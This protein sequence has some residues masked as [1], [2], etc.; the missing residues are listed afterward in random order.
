MAVVNLPLNWWTGGHHSNNM[1][2]VMSDLCLSLVM[3]NHGIKWHERHLINY[4]RKRV[5]GAPEVMLCAARVQPL[6]WRENLVVFF[7]LV[8]LANF[9]MS[10]LQLGQARSQTFRKGGDKIV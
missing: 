8:V 3:E 5:G 7:Q 1:P 9:R 10:L 6:I 2:G 4:A